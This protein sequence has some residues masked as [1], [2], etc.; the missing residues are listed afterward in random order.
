MSRNKAWLLWGAVLLA[1]FIAGILSE[2]STSRRVVVAAATLGAGLAA[3]L[4]VMV[5]AAVLRDR[6]GRQAPAVALV[7]AGAASVAIAQLIP[8]GLAGQVIMAGL[9]GAT[10]GLFA[11]SAPDHRN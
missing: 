10:T 11:H 7:L 9:L 6:L 1:I 5:I 4:A 3:Y 8:G 2:T